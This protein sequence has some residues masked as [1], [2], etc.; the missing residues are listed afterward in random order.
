MYLFD[1]HP[2]VKGSYK[3]GREQLKAMYKTRDNCQA[4]DQCWKI[5]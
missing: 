2:M 1:K 3:V 4:I 5:R